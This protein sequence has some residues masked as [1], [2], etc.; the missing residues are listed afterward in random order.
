MRIL[1]LAAL[2][3]AI[4]SASWAANEKANEPTLRS[5][6]WK[7]QDSETHA[8]L[9]K[10]HKRDDAA[11]EHA[12]NQERQSI[13]EFELIEPPAG[14]FAS[15]PDDGSQLPGQQVPEVTVQGIDTDIRTYD[16]NDPADRER[17]CADAREICGEMAAGVSSTTTPAT[18]MTMQSVPVMNTETVCVNGVCYAPGTFQMGTT[19]M[20][21]PSSSAYSTPV[22]Y[23]TTYENGS[24][25]GVSASYAMP[26]SYG[27][28]RPVVTYNEV[29]AYGGG[30]AFY[31]GSQYSNGSTG[32]GFMTSN[33]AV[34]SSGSMAVSDVTFGANPAGAPAFRSGGGLFS[35]LRARR[36]ARAA[37]NLQRF[38]LMQACQN[39][40]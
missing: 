16:L 8:E 39:C 34:Y 7:Y 21:V 18:P 1:A 23:S 6:A 24:A 11:A 38:K 29:P 4:A 33:G 32:G 40:N 14:A 20:S 5:V 15:Q 31:S 27:Y 36:A 19:Q 12:R 22:S 30:P 37:S 3:F 9:A 26:V 35:R 13:I 28:Q 2:I 25:G 10:Q 17:F